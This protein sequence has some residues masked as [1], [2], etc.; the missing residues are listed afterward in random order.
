MQ[1]TAHS[2][3]TGKQCARPAINGAVVCRVPGGAAPQV[4]AAARLRLL[5]AAD[6]VAGVL[7]SQALGKGK[8]YKNLPAAEKRAA[9]IA[10]IDRAGLKPT[11]K[12]ELTGRDG[13]PIKTLDLSKFTTEELEFFERIHKRIEQPEQTPPKPN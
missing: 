8:E 1:C 3:S 5:M 7:V 2:K 10:V 6:S 9:A 13:G 11:D 4:I 12:V